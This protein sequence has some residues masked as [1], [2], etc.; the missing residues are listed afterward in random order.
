[1][2]RSHLVFGGDVQGGEVHREDIPMRLHSTVWH[3]GR[4]RTMDTAVETGAFTLRGVSRSAGA[5]MVVPPRW[6]TG[7]RRSA[8]SNFLE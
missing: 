3:G 2:A 8:C 4:F 6:P 1:M 7:C 5:S